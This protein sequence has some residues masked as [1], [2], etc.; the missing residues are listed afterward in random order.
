MTVKTI[1]AVIGAPDIR[2]DLEDA[3]Q[4]CRDVDAHLS[5]LVTQM[6]S[7]P[8]LGDPGVMATVWLEER[9]AQMAHLRQSEDVARNMLASADISG[10]VEGRLLDP[11]LAARTLGERARY[12]DLT[13]V[14]RALRS[15]PD[16][17]AATLDGCL[18]KSGRPILV[19]PRTGRMTLR[20]KTVMVAW[21]G[22]L[23]AARAVQ[24]GLGLISTAQTVLVV[25]VDPDAAQ[26][27][28]GEEPG[29]DI[30]HA[31][32]RH[33]ASVEVQRLPSM[34][35]PVAEVLN[36]HAVDASADL[37]IM[38]G[39]GHSRIREQIFGG[40]TRSAIEMFSVPV[41]MVH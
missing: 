16:L 5:V 40:T 20:P 19:A 9:E 34:G 11:G 22:G 13:L 23:E 31:L 15:A 37:V 35:R 30:G 12:A 38:G 39:Y 32:A 29:A 27:N 3:I 7:L 14:E 4:L 28:G 2:G 8:P 24:A 6:V 36:R 33:G 41:F 1:G 21:D 18:F 26:E 17:A 25:L 10:T